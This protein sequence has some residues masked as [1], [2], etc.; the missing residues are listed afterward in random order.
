MRAV[1]WVA[2]SKKLIQEILRI[3]ISRIEGCGTSYL[4]DMS[5]VK[6]LS[7]LH[8][9]KRDRERERERER[10]LSALLIFTFIK[11]ITR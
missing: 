11:L 6:F 8:A 3:L 2:Y 5:V 7:Q 1:L 4:K 9:T 10:D